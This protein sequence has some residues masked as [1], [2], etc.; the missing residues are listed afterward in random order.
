M[1][2]LAYSTDGK[3]LFSAG[4]DGN[5]NCTNLARKKNEYSFLS[6]HAGSFK[7][8]LYIFNYNFLSDWIMSLSINEKY[9]A[10][11]ATDNSIKLFDLEEQQLIKT[12]ANPQQCNLC[13]N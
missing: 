10:S 8:T 4:T 3:V 1:T 9:L 6:A 7:K 13:I 2:A 11:G 5:I 12:F